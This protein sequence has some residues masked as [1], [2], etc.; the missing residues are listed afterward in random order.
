M[1]NGKI[2][3]PKNDG[4]CGDEVGFHLKWAVF[5]PKLKR[6]GCS[7]SLSGCDSVILKAGQ[8]TSG[9]V[10]YVAGVLED[11]GEGLEGPNCV[12]LRFP[13]PQPA[14][15]LSMY[16]RLALTEPIRGLDLPGIILLSTFQ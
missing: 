6:A 14:P 3:S 11:F 16:K 7:V 9:T 4:L 10:N 1:R 15:V 2:S 5:I 8:G 13:T 12:S